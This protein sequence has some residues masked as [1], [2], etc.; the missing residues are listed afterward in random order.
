[1]PIKTYE[2]IGILNRYI[3]AVIDGRE[4]SIPMTNGVESPRRI[5][6]RY[7]TSDPKIQNWI[8]NSGNFNKRYRLISTILTQQEMQGRTG[9]KKTAVI[10]P[11]DH[12]DDKAVAPNQITIIGNEDDTGM[13]VPEETDEDVL[14][15]P[16]AEETYTANPGIT[17]V[18]EVANGQQARN[19]LIE[20][21][22]DLT[23]RQVA[24]N[25]QIIT[26]AKARNIQFPQWE[27]FVTSKLVTKQ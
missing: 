7:T 1:M 8:E 22:K 11:E 13:S 3:N 21:C 10:P 20:H 12:D 19:Y 4:V 16:D 5:Q 15:N 26:E 2:T 17:V 24:N 14:P 25:Q 27:A 18:D 23:F 6:G 9:T